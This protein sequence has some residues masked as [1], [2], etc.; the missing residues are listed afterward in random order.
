MIVLSLWLPILVSAVI[1]FVASSI[2]HMVL[3]Y[4]RSDFKKLEKEDE[5][6]DALRP[7]N[8]PPGDYILP[9]AVTPGEMKS[10][11]YKDKIE[12]GPVGIF[13]I[14]PNKMTSMGPQ[15]LMWFIYCIVVGLFA[16][17]AAGVSLGAGANYLTVFRV[18]GSVAVAGYCFGILQNSI[19]FGRS[20]SATLK[21]FFDGVIY[22]LLTAGTFGWLWPA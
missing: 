3:T 14:L 8:I 16:A 9:R 5:V 15:L 10:Q 21:H 12:K 6:G 2:I 17:Y 4:H 20:W 11:E 7:F 13:T 19:W 1:V 22:A 18:T